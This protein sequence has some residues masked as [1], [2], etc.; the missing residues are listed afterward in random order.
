MI[1]N[2]DYLY[3]DWHKIKFPVKRNN[4]ALTSSMAAVRSCRSVFGATMKY[5]FEIKIIFT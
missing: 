1:A 2:M 5:R 4:I 3:N